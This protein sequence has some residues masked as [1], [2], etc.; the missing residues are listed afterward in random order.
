[1]NKIE[2]KPQASTLW[3]RNKALNIKIKKDFIITTV[4]GKTYTIYAG[5]YKVH[6]SISYDQFDIDMLKL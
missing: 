1:M 6:K 5:I 4:D 3:N 2:I